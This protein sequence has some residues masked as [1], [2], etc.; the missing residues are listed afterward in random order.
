MIEL[1]DIRNQLKHSLQSLQSLG[2]ELIRQRKPRDDIPSIE[3]N[4]LLKAVRNVLKIFLGPLGET[5][6]QIINS[7]LDVL[8]GIETSLTDLIGE[9]SLPNRH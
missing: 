6:F 5:L 8:V 7:L 2:S 4:E 9:N 3:D 1:R